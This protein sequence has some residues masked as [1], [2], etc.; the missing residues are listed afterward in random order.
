MNNEIL[1]LIEKCGRVYFSP[2]ETAAAVGI[3]I[4]QMKEYLSLEDHPAQQAYQRGRHISLLEVR[5][6]IFKMAAN[7]SG[8][9]QTMVHKIIEDYEFREK[10]KK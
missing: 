10:A 3:P 7:G 8:P 5:M 6:S 9:A 4:K 2:E 1:D